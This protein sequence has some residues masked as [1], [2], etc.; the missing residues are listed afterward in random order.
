MT[1]QTMRL[2]NTLLVIFFLFV[3][4]GVYGQKIIDDRL[5]SVKKQDY[6]QA[7]Q[8]ITYEE[9]NTILLQSENP[10][11]RLNLETADKNRKI[12]E[13]LSYLGGF[14]LGFSMGYGL[15][16]LI[17]GDGFDFEPISAISAASFLTLSIPFSR[18]AKK[19][20]VGAITIYNEGIVQ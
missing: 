17:F 3:N 13:K 20:T 8:Q 5:I 6:F 14:A 7:N 1:K 12:S 9:L 4:T 15:G 11:I 16:G 18:K 19:N 10:E 2:F